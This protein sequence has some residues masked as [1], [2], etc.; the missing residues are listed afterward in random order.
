MSNINACIRV[1]KQMKTLCQRLNINITE[2]NPIKNLFYKTGEIDSEI[3]TF[4]FLF[5]IEVYFITY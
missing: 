3:K 5:L 4:I 1:G 2:Q